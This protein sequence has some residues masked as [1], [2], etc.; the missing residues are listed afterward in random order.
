MNKPV[1]RLAPSPTGALHLGNARTFLINWAMARQAGWRVVL[2]IEDLDVERVRDEGYRD[3]CESLTWLGMDWDDGPIYQRHD[4]MPYQHAV[5]RLYGLGLIYPCRASRR[6]IQHAMSAP[7]DSDEPARDGRDVRYPGLNRPANGTRT[8]EAAPILGQPSDAAWR[9]RVP[10]GLIEYRDRFHGPQS[11]DVQGQVGDFVVVAKNGMPGYQL[12]VVVDDARQCVTHVLR[13][14][15]LLSSGARQLWLYRLLELEPI[16]VYTHVPLVCDGH[17]R[18]LA[19][20]DD[21]IRLA[22]YREQGIAP[23]RI[24]GLIAKWCGIIAQ[25]QPIRPMEAGEFCE[26]FDLATMPRTTVNFTED[27]HA[28][29]M[30]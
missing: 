17:G 9:L 8:S 23:Q 29:L 28:W 26:R 1:T 20:R 19:K 10:D 11:F 12:A 25:D 22:W 30:A 3:A 24:I 7:H 21:D 16:P 4:L 2:R 14:D 27:E 5:D 18:R 13:G 15:D 6:D